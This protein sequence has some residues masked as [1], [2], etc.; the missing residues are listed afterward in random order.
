M[1]GPYSLSDLRLLE[2][3]TEEELD[4]YY[5]LRW[6][7]LRQPWDQPRGSERDDLDAESYK[8]MLKTPGDRAVAVGRLHF[9]SPE[10][11]QVRYM[12][13]DPEWDRSG[14]GS[15]ILKGLEDEA[16]KRGARTIILNSRDKAVGFYEKH[17]YALSGQ[18]AALFGGKVQ[19]VRMSKTI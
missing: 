1:L 19:H 11:A 13:V 6:R 12:A 10:Q 16:R 18:A 14:L 5:D 2:P 17:G 8:L 15:R 3:G 9:N 4:A 7:I